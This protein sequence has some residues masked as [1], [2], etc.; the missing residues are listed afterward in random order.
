M[1]IDFITDDVIHW[2]NTYHGPR[3]HALFCDPP[4]ELAFMGK[5]WDA[6]G[7]A[8]RPDTW[9]AL[10]EHL[11][12]GAFLMAF[13]GS[14]TYHRM[15][16]AIEDAGLIIHP[17]ILYLY[18]SGFPKATRIDTQI[19]KA[20]GAERET[21]GKVRGMGKQ[22]PQWNGTAQGRKEN[23]LKSEYDATV[24][25]TSLART[26]AG[27][28]YGLQA[29][30]PAA[31]F[32]C[33]AQ[34]PYQGRPV[35]SIVESGAGALWIEGARIGTEII[36]SN[37]EGSVGLDKRRFEQGTRPRTYCEKQEPTEHAGRWP[38]NL[39]LDSDAAQALDEMS[40]ERRSSGIYNRGEMG[41]PSGAACIDIRPPAGI[42]GY[43]DSGGASRFFFTYQS[44]A[45]DDADPFFYCAK[46]SRRERD[47][48]LDGMPIQKAGAMRGNVTDEP[49][50]LA[51]DHITPVQPVYGR[52]PHPTVKPLALCRYLATLLLPPAEYAPRRLLVPF[53]GVCSEAIGAMQ[54]GWDEITA[55][56]R[57]LDYVEIGIA[58][59][60]Y[61]RKQVQQL[62]LPV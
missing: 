45:L 5:K 47:K 22:N 18:G 49:T 53:S 2:A 55:I 30:K 32:I 16:C 24:P 27:H 38:A 41:D 52:N 51:G 33:V 25:S 4:Y 44:D 3:F 28:R 34:K 1:T 46:S 57:E 60:E 37:G 20:A 61:W 62:T 12:P 23:S 54:A 56:E 40:G 8:F 26:W 43:S 7:I 36:R 29:L 31:E 14:R 50:R 13:G 48:G 58:R 59:V 15:A 39:L 42:A 6:T 11:L 19:D 9:G 35:E 21:V 17:A 10:A